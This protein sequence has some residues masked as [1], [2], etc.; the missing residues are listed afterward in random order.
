MDR[1][2]WLSLVVCA[3]VVSAGCGADP[4]APGD[5]DVERDPNRGLDVGNPDRSDGQDVDVVSTDDDVG[6]DDVGDDQTDVDA[7][8]DAERVEPE[9]EDAELG[10][11]A[12]DDV[13]ADDDAERVEPEGEDAELDSPASEDVDAA[14]DDGSGEHEDQ[15]V[16]LDTVDDENNETDYLEEG[17]SEEEV[18]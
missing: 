1:K 6:E 13:D 11:P 3:L 16:E 12:S 17:E 14:D 5:S 10:T 15:D 2:Y 4:L 8:D 7:A 18:G 9:G